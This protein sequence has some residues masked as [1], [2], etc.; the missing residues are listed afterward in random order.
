MFKFRF[1]IKR[2]KKG[3][4]P[5]WL[6]TL[7]GPLVAALFFVFNRETVVVGAITAIVMIAAM[8]WIPFSAWALVAIA[9]IVYGLNANW[10]YR[11]Q[12]RMKGKTGK[13]DMAALIAMVGSIVMWAC[14]IAIIVILV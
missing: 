7:L 10:I 4:Q 9:G 5:S 1:W 2:E 11:W 13:N 8:T 6:K 12:V 3:F 14:I